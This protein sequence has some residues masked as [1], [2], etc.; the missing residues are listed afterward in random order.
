MRI[1]RV[2]PADEAALKA[3][4]EIYVICGREQDSFVP[5][6]YAELVDVI[7]TP[8]EDFAYTAFL[9]YDGD[10][11]V[12][13]GWFAEFRR[14]NLDKAWA[15]PRTLPQHRRRGVGSALLAH[16]EAHGRT[17]G[18][19]VLQASPR[20]PMAYGP[21]GTGAP[22]LEF[23]RRHG[24]GLKLVEAKRS[25][26]LP[27]AGSVLDELAGRVDPAYTVTA[28]SGPVPDDLVEGWAALEASLAT[29]APTGDME[30]DE[31]PASVASIRHDER[32]LA[33]SGR[34]KYN[35]VAIA[36]DGEV[37]G[38]TDIVAGEVGEPAPQWGTLVRRAHRGHGLGHGLKAAVLRLLQEERP[39][40][41]ATITSNALANAAMMAVNDRLGYRVVE[42]L[43]DVQKRM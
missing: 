16:M 39:D 19:T 14:A 35:A 34:L 37:V 8:T 30:T 10:E 26:A 5:S 11:P 27:V 9:A 13:E 41:T 17:L 32:L 25:L 29:E 4:Y 40:I 12:G 33:E 7:R 15:T 21:D 28:F 1:E 31:V 36:P 24:Y 42:Y 18:R 23:A 6:P 43:G 22:T 20:W 38:Y 3:F 2:D